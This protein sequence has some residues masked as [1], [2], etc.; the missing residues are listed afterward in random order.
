MA[1]NVTKFNSIVKKVKF[2]FELKIYL[3][4]EAS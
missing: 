2:F 3:H 1:I 4:T